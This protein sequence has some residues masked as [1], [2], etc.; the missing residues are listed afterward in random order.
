MEDLTPMMKQYHDVKRRFP[1]KLVF[2][3]LGDFYEM[4]YEDAVVAAQD[5]EITLTARNRDKAGAPIPMCGVPH[6]AVDAYV[7]RLLKKGHKIVICEQT[8]PPAEGKK[9]IR[10]EVTRVL[11]PGTVV[12]DVLLDPKD[13]NYL[14]SW[15]AR[16]GSIGLAVLDLSTGE[17]LATEIGGDQSWS[18]AV[19]E[20]G[21]FAPREVLLPD[22]AAEE[23]RARLARDWPG[24]WVASPIESWAFNH[25]YGERL[26]VEQFRVATLAGFGCEGR[27]LAVSAAGALVHYLR[28]TQF[29]QVGHVASMRCFEPGDTLVLDAATIRNLELVETL[30]GARKG[31][32]LDSL[33]R[34]RS[35]MG[36]RLLKS[37]LLSPLRDVGQLELRLDA[38]GALARDLV[39]RER[40]I[41]SLGQVHDLERLTSRITLGTATPRELVA[42][43]ASLEALPGIRALLGA[44]AAPRLAAIRDELEELADVRA[45]I[46]GAIADNPP[47]SAAE[48]G[49][50]RGGYSPELDELRAIR[51]SGKEFIARMEARERER[52]AIQSL[53]VKYNGVFGYFIEVTRPNLPQVPADYRRRQTLANCERFVTDELESYE[54]K[55][56][57]A[58]ERIAELERELFL[59]CRGAVADEARRILR[60]ARLVAELDVY[61]SLAQVAVGNDYARP[62]LVST[63]ELYIRQGRHPMVERHSRPFIPNDLYANTTTDQL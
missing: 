15:I 21:R 31:S 60:A 52:T 4:F 6:H 53:K 50:I 41:A 42:L 39:G 38:V 26:L 9:L 12:E 16:D 32:L 63:D 56:L 37:W 61:A 3:R 40:L 34:T 20:I 24:D 23:L 19:D 57:G 44:F 11:T 29:R 43:A 27:P 7:A 33:D 46:R 47:A 59:A 13:P 51:H 18:R 10:R 17:F 45:R 48:P 1:G 58:E 49:I 55:V 5:L 30:E 25:D 2:F 36:G 54:A 28:E 14:A 22:D 8:E 62:E 35:G